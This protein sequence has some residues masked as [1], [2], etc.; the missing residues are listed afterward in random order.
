MKRSY[1]LPEAKDVRVGFRT[2]QTRA[3]S[4]ENSRDTLPVYTVGWAIKVQPNI[5]P[6]IDSEYGSQSDLNNACRKACFEVEIL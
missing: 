3:L 5:Y 1:L 2:F 6:G 4:P